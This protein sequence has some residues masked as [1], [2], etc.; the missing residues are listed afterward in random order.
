MA[1]SGDKPSLNRSLTIAS[2]DATKK[3]YLYQPFDR[4]NSVRKFYNNPLDVA[5]S[6]DEDEGKGNGKVKGTVKQLCSL[7][8]S[9]K[10]GRA[11]AKFLA[12]AEDRIVVY[13]TSLRG[14]R[15][16]YEDCYAVRMIFRGFRVYVDERDVSMDSAYRRELL[17]VLNQN[18]VS[19]PQVFI[20]GAYVGGADVVKQL[21]ETGQLLKM[22]KGLPI[23]TAGY[24]CQACGDV[25]F[26]PCLNCSG[27]KK[28]YDEDEDMVKRCRVCNENG[29]IRCPNCCL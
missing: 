7:F 6:T 14:V 13:F 11:P 16:T 20:K 26:I 1:N 12:G 22:V 21:H 15:R 24:V 4:S 17:K 8:E 10:I 27:S 9:K 18:T 3:P 19:L 5:A 29:L 28:L 25:R 2:T 23:K